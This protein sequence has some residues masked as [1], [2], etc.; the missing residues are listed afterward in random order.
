MKNVNCK[1]R[2]GVNF[3]WN[4]N[5]KLHRFDGQVKNKNNLPKAISVGETNEQ[6][7]ILHPVIIV[8][9]TFDILNTCVGASTLARFI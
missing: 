7:L 1:Q 6:A 9:I 8:I 5:M 2:T 3:T 4:N